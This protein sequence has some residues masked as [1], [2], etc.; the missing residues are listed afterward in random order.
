MDTTGLFPHLL[1]K[2]P[3]HLAISPDTTCP[4]AT[5]P[6]LGCHR[7]RWVGVG[8]GVGC[9]RVLEGVGGLQKQHIEID[10][11]GS[12]YATQKRHKEKAHVGLPSHTTEATCKLE[13]KHKQERW[14]NT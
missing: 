10:E 8:V 4:T 7:D 9:W 2:A 13:M 14:R 12:G 11:P 6:H 3:V 5:E 1:N